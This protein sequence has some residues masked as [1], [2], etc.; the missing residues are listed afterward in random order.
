[1]FVEILD[2]T[3]EIVGANPNLVNINS[4]DLKSNEIEEWTDI[5]V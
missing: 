3:M 4:E 5:P 1:M 2:Y